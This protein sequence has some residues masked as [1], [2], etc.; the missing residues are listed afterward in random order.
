MPAYR[1]TPQHIRNLADRAKAF[2]RAAAV[3]LVTMLVVLAPQPADA[4][5]VVFRYNSTFAYPAFQLVNDPGMW[6]M[7][8][9]GV[10]LRGR[11]SAVD[12]NPA[13]IGRDGYV[14]AGIDAGLNPFVGTEYDFVGEN[15]VERSPFA[16]VK[17]GRWAVAAQVNIYTSASLELRDDDGSIRGEID[18]RHYSAK[19]F[20]AFDVTDAWTL[21]GAIGYTSDNDFAGSVFSGF[22]VSALTID[23]GAH[24]EW[25]RQVGETATLRP[26][27][28][29]SLMHFGNNS[30]LQQGVEIP[31]PTRLRLGS[32]L[33]FQRG[34][35]WYDRSPFSATAHLELS[36]EMVSIESGASRDVSSPFGALIEAWRTELRSGRSAEEPFDR[37]NAWQQTEKHL[38]AEVSIYEVLDLRL[39]RSQGSEEA[40]LNALTTFGVGVD[41]VYFRLDY[42]GT[43]SSRYQLGGDRSMLRVTAA[44]PL[45]GR[46]KNNWLA[47]VF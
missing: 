42:G 4:Q 27:V 23:L 30:A 17:L 47:E 18:P 25:E 34:E 36:K 16:T 21:G 38:G 44:I 29:I 9:G 28:G 39:G 13:A 46:Y 14:Q 1:C 3:A 43:L 32:A 10:A 11:P 45:D 19:V 22:G 15:P 31:T 37:A 35:K 20:T 33:K 8:R 2:A 41:L 40:Q 12:V 26:S 5:N 6:A 24:G 7:G